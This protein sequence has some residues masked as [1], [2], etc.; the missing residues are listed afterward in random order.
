MFTRRRLHRDDLGWDSYYPP[1]LC[2]WYF[3]YSKVSLWSH[4][5][6]ITLKDLWFNMGM[7]INTDKT[8]AMIKNWRK[9][10]IIYYNRKLEEMNSYNYL[11]IDIHHKL[12]WNYSI[13]KR[14]SYLKIF[15]SSL[16]CTVVKYGDA[17]FLENNG[18]GLSK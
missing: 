18:E 11:G 9:T 13:E 14:S 7:T 1:A 4:K 16:Y 3:S 15:P 5:Q 6:L 10:P 17:S 8:K 2:W 12:N